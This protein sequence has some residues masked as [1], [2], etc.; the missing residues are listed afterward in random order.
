MEGAVEAVDI[1]HKV[2]REERAIVGEGSTQTKMGSVLQQQGTNI[3][4]IGIMKKGHRGEMR[5]ADVHREIGEKNIKKLKLYWSFRISITG[6]KIPSGKK[7]FF[8]DKINRIV[9]FA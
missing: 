8:S 7:K 4:I 3:N 1:G 2:T 9:S 5:T 6:K